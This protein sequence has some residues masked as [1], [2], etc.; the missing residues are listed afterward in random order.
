MRLERAVVIHGQAHGIA[1]LDAASKVSAAR[2]PARLVLLSAHGAA[3][4]LGA[5]WWLAL[6]TLLQS[7]MAACGAADCLDCGAAAGRAMEAL[8]LGQRRLILSRDCPQFEAVLERAAAQGAT[9]ESV[10]P[11]ALDLAERHAERRL[12]PWLEG[13]GWKE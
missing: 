3:G 8:R 10:R 13:V 1:A 5:G 11:P 6:T 12:R 2:G 4:F 7:R 9:L